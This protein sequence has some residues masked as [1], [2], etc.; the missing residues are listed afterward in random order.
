[1]KDLFNNFHKDFG[2]QE[3]NNW[4]LAKWKGHILH[5]YS[6]WGCHKN[7]NNNNMIHMCPFRLFLKKQFSN[8]LS[9]HGKLGLGR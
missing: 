5:G 8:P 9:C 6:T 2:I 4:L 3:E 1:L 7:N